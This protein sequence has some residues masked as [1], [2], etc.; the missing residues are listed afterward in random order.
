MLL[1]SWQNVCVW[2]C[3]ELGRAQVD[4]RAGQLLLHLRHDLQLVGADCEALAPDFL[5][6]KVERVDA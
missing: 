5:H 6:R 4:V 2:L 1:P 3:H